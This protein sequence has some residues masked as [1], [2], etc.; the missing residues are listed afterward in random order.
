MQWNNVVAKPKAVWS[1]ELSTLEVSLRFPLGA[2][3]RRLKIWRPGSLTR[4]NIDYCSACCGQHAS[5]QG[6]QGVKRRPVRSSATN[7]RLPFSFFFPMEGPL[8]L[9]CQTQLQEV[10]ESSS[11]TLLK[12]SVTCVVLVTASRI[13]HGLHG[14]KLSSSGSILYISF[15]PQ[16]FKMSS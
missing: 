10:V 6:R 9:F 7:H 16:A 14:P 12:H 2:K 1:W 15:A 13:T 4:L 5:T 11:R 8:P 3:G